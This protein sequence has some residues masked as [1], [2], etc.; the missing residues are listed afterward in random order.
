MVVW[1]LDSADVISR[2]GLVEHN[3]GRAMNDAGT[4]EIVSL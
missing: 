3:V 4:E 1:L 2:E